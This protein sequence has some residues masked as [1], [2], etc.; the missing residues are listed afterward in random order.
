M[1]NQNKT[2]YLF[3]QFNEVSS[4]TL[5]LS[6]TSREPH[7]SCNQRLQNPEFYSLQASWN[8][9]CLRFD[10]KLVCITVKGKEAIEFFSSE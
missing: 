6:V 8:K 5:S 2:F 10:G 7:G 4:E 1:T 3:S 9:E